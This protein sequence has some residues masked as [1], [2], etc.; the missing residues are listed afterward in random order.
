M[1]ELD[2]DEFHVERMGESLN[3]IVAGA[4][5]HGTT[6]LVK[7]G[8]YGCVC[9]KGGRVFA[10]YKGRTVGFQ[11][12][13]IEHLLQLFL[14]DDQGTPFHQAAREAEQVILF[15]YFIDTS[16][17][18]Y[19]PQACLI[20]ALAEALLSLTYDTFEARK[21]RFPAYAAD[22]SQSWF[23]LRDHFGL[24]S[25]PSKV[26][27]LNSTPCWEKLEE[28]FD[29][30]TAL[31][32]LWS[33][34]LSPTPSSP[35]KRQLQSDVLAAADLATVLTVPAID[36]GALHGIKSPRDINGDAFA[37][38]LGKTFNCVPLKMVEEVKELPVLP[39]NRRGELADEGIDTATVMR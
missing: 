38:L 14:D 10:R 4:L 39:R 30:R 20:R 3:R 35:I 8:C 7:A 36:A 19:S 23:Q 24:L 15:P 27:K 9:L 32:M 17:D 13:G 16:N 34:P 1:I 11:Y 6:T 12:R 26:R 22:V 33:R 21:N 5:L 25:W 29:A 31:A 28:S 2:G 37:H 18:P